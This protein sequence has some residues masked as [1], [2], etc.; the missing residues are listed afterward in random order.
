VRT[1]K[2]FARYGTMPPE[3]AASLRTLR[4]VPVDVEPEWDFPESVPTAH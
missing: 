2:W 4:D 1:E 3:L